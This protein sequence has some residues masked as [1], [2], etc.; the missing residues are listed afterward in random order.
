MEFGNFLSAVFGSWVEKVGIILTLVPFIEKAPPVKRWL[1]NRPLLEKF[2]SILLW[3]G[4][5]VVFWGFYDAWLQQVNQVRDLRAQNATLQQH[6]SSLQVPDLHGTITNI[7]FGRPPRGGSNCVLTLQAIIT[8]TGAPSVADRITIR[9]SL[10]DRTNVRVEGLLPPPGSITL[11]EGFPRKSPGIILMSS[12]YL[13]NKALA[14]PIKTG[15][16]VF[17][18]MQAYIEGWTSKQIETKGAI[19]RL[20]FYDV[21]GKSYTAELQTTRKPTPFPRSLER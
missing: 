9:V 17:G 6:L 10:K 11:F 2:T 7:M 13:P 18:F 15:G 19:V 21:T 16:A 1:R 12:D 20:V 5:L 8:N 3:V 14:E 4:V